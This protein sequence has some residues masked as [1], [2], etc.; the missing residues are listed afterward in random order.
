MA[1]KDNK[2]LKC[3]D[4]VKAVRMQ[5]DEELREQ[6]WIDVEILGQ[7]LTCH[8]FALHVI[9][10]TNLLFPAETMCFP[11]EDTV[12]KT[13]KS[14]YTKA[15]VTLRSLILAC[16]N[17]AKVMTIENGD[18]C[19]AEALTEM[20]HKVPS[21]IEDWQKSSARGAARVALAMCLARNSALDLDLVTSGVPLEVNDE[22]LLKTCMGYDNR[23]AESINHSDWYDQVVFEKDSALLAGT[24]ES[25][26]ESSSSS[27]SSEA[28]DEDEEP[29][30]DDTPS[31][32]PKTAGSAAP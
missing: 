8:Y 32:P 7:F 29:K 27:S 9:L 2:V 16:R 22:E 3:E 23:V 31:Y 30:V 1:E 15:G 5:L 4:T 10:I 21:F 19:D 28:E 24:S 6:D 26:N 14:L 17:I 18:T 12:K 20:M 13:R 25:S 11:R